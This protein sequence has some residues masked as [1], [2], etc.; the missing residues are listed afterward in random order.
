[1]LAKREYN[2]NAHLCQ[3]REV[4]WTTLPDLASALLSGQIINGM[5]STMKMLP[6]SVFLC[7]GPVPG[8]LGWAYPEQPGLSATA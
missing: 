8:L 5:L 1:M 6:G 2:L 7:P 3:A 4:F